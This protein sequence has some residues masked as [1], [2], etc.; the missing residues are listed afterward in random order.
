MEEIVRVRADRREWYGQKTYYD[1]LIINSVP[2]YYL[3]LDAPLS[4]DD[5]N[6]PTINLDSTVVTMTS[7]IVDQVRIVATFIVP[8]RSLLD[9]SGGALVKATVEVGANARCTTLRASMVA[10]DRTTAAERIIA[11]EKSIALNIDGSAARSV[12]VRLDW[13]PEFNLRTNEVLAYRV[14][15][16]GRQ[17]ASVAVPAP[18]M[19]WH[20]RGLGDCYVC[21]RTTEAP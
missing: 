6:D 15:L 13:E 4:V 17:V 14:R 12:S 5:D 16:F 2:Q 7:D 10:I 9:V 19:L 3:L 21:T 20:R 18:I 11:P 8:H 1:P